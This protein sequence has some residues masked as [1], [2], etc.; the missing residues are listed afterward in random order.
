MTKPPTV[1]ELIWERD[2]VFSV[3]APAS[4]VHVR[5]LKIDSDSA[6]GPSPMQLVAMGLA[7]CMAIDLVHIL[8]K[9]R[10]DLR[11]LRAELTGKRA[12]TEPRRFTQM[13]LLFELTG[14]ILAEHVDRAIQLSRDK[15]CSVWH[16]LR[17]DIDLHVTYTIS[18][19]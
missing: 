7:G 19:R 11:G 5:R 12:E 6:A 16:S 2:L 8:K 1:V 14:D 18:G 4:A 9:G 15:Y 13:T 10:H 17:Q 3:E